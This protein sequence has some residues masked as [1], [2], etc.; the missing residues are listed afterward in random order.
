M[1][2]NQS[3]ELMRASSIPIQC[4]KT[5]Q[6]DCTQNGSLIPICKKSRLDIPD[7]AILR[8]WSCPTTKKQDQ[9]AELRASTYLE[10]KRKLTVSIRWILRSVQNSV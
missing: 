10:I 9:N 6:Q 4:V 2:A 5:S 7:L 3:L 8:T 1:S